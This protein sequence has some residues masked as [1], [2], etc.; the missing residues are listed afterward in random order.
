MAILYEESDWIRRSQQGD[1]EAFAALIK[2]YQHMIHALTFRMTGSMADAEDMA[3]E[4]FIRAFRQLDGYR[5]EAAFS[6]WLYRIAVNLCLNL[7]TRR[8]RREKLHDDWGQHLATAPEPEGKNTRLVQEALMKLNPKQR[9]AVV[10]TTYD[11]LN[12]A[13]AAKVLGC[14]ETTV[15]WRVFAARNKL[16]RFL[17]DAMRK[18]AA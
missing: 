10:L 6:S 8:Q 17:T 15:S 13:E 12:H 1:H 3:Q 14:S 18:E 4:T 11:G 16:K 9:A 7:R 5:S 2:R